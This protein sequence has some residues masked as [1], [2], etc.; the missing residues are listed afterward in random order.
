MAA[1]RR[2]WWGW[3]ELDP[4]WARRLVAD[5]GVRPGDL[6]VDVGAGTGGLTRALVD[7]GAK[8]IAV[9]LHPARCQAL[10]ERFGTNPAVVVVKA[11]AAD[12]RL[13]TRPFRVVA[14]PP[15]AVS[16]ALL[17]RL[18]APGSR[19]VQADLVLPRPVVARWAGGRGPGAQRWMR[20]FDAQPGRSLPGA[21]FRPPPPMAVGT[22]RIVRVAGRG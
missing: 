11:D 2:P 18:L 14:N 3:H 22:L 21:A 10:R 7:A 4:R 17:R 9:E 15:F 6:V 1:P 5:A 12:L 19:L 13:P 16:T 20:T 8:V